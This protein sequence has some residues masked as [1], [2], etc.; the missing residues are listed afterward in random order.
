MAVFRPGADDLRLIGYQ[1]GKVATGLSLLMAVPAVV[2][3]VLGEW[4]AATALVVGAGICVTFGQ[5]SEW[6]LRTSKP[7]TWSHGTVVVALAWLVGSALA[8]IPFL[9][10]GHTGNLLDAWFEAMSG[11]TT[12]GLSVIQDLDHLSYSMNLYRHLTHFAGGQ[13]IV[14]VV[15]AV[16]ASGSGAGMLYVAEGREDRILPNIVRTARFIFMVAAV[17][18]VVGTIALYG[19]LHLAGLG[20]W[21]GLWHAVN[22]FVAAFDTGGFTPTSQSI[23]YY[24]SATVEVVL[25]VLMVAGT[26]SFALHYHLWAG[27]FRELTRNLEVRSLLVTATVLGTLTLFGLAR[28]GVQSSAAGLYRKGIFTLL[29]AHT[30]TGFA[31][32]A[33]GLI[34]SDWGVLAPAAIVLA[35]GLGGMAGSTAGGVKALRVGITAKAIAHD[36]RRILLPDGAV[37]VTTYH[38]GHKRILRDQVARSATTVLLLYVATYLAGALVALLYGRW[39]ASEALFESVSAAANVGLSVGIVDPSMPRLLQVTYILQMWVGRLEFVAA[40]ALVGYL[41]AVVRGRR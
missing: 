13:G 1:L 28:S 29:S 34:V 6:R 7:L 39:E 30:G 10:S 4:N 5:L 11:L 20:G 25:L 26:M 15:L 33:G 8:A 32:N 14:I 31:V 35:M 37:A 27:R 40:F 17:Y 16:L 3:V 38:A 23:G 12:S 2:A 18:L 36:I 22:L 9:L 24:H 21:R 19:T 41:V